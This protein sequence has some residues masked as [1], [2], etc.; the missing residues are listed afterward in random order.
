MPFE[1]GRP[2]G[3]P[4]DIEFQKKVLFSLLNLFENPHGPVI[5]HDFPEDAP[6]AGGGVE[7]LSCPVSFEHE[8]TDASD[9][10][11]AR[12]MRE[13][14]AMHPW[15]EMA[16]KNRNRTTLGGSG[17]EISSLGDFLY[18]FVVGSIPENPRDDVD[19]SL[20]L[21]LAAEDLKAYYIEA[22]T[23]QPGQEELSS[24]ALKEWFWNR[25]TAGSVLLELIKVCSKSE[26]E[27]IRVTG[28]HFIAPMDVLMKY[29][30]Q[31]KL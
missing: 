31:P 9:P 25:T 29:G 21:K 20:T 4:N 30:I 7:V 8:E 17:I 15:Y 19:I 23:S 11:K 5:I 6:E 18:S 24:S 3:V 26:D 2:L 14:Q 10:L 16:L 28:S 1:L 22:V 27:L 13:I 12:F